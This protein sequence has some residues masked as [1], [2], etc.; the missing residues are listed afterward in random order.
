MGRRGFVLC[1]AGLFIWVG[2]ACQKAKTSELSPEW[3]QARQKIPLYEARGYRLEWIDTAGQRLSI[4]ARQVSRLKRGDTVTWRMVGDVYATHLTV[5]GDTL[6]TLR[7]ET[8]TAYPDRQSFI[9]ERNVFLKTSDGL[10]LE[11]DYLVWEQDKNL[12]TAPGWVRLQTPK[13]TLRGEG[14]EYHTTN[15]TYKLRR[16]RGT[17]Q[18]PI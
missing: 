3:V 2:T 18:S 4:S 5:R 9:A 17:V 7:S 14:L 16:T 13:E 1:G 11:T 15:R 12:I 6:E 8:A 10:R